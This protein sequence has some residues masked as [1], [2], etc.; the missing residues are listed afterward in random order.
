MSARHRA[1]GNVDVLR[2]DL[3]TLRNDI[4]KLAQELPAKLN[5]VGDESLQ[6]ARERITRMKASLDTSLSQ[7][8]DRGREA[9]RA[10]ND[11]STTASQAIE[12]SLDAH[13]VAT[14]ALA[15]GLGYLLGAMSRR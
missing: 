10:V 7:L 12:E 9:A 13:P 6:A 3:Q 2:H 1:N 15:V 14:V 5:E 11:V 8:S 4:A